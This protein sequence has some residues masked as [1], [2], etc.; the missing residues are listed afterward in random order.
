VVIFIKATDTTPVILIDIEP[1]EIYSWAK[2]RL[3]MHSIN[4]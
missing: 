1:S 2:S 4:L 3:S